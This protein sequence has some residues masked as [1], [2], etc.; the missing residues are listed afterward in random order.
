MEQI[1]IIIPFYN[2]KYVDQAIQSA[3]NQTYPDKEI[4]VVNDGSTKFLNKL[5]KFLDKIRYVEKDH[6][7]TA[8]ALNLG[9]QKARG[10]YITWLS[11]DDV[12]KREKLASQVKFMKE[13]EAAIS[14]SPY[15]RIDH[16]N[17]LV[18]GN[19]E[20]QYYYDTPMEF[21]RHLKRNCFINGSTIMIKK[22]LF[23]KIGL[24]DEKLVYAQDYDFWLRAAKHYKVHY[25]P[26]P[27]VYYRIHDDMGSIQHRASLL[28]EYIQVKRIHRN[29]VLSKMSGLK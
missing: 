19:I 28:K 25:H 5:N 10:D 1:S 3:L 22:E 27:N 13:K 14:Y 26:E 18:N 24:F 23:A 15:F 16:T 9:I 21:F 6:G 29:V 7:G 20:G 17:K 4:I 11:S 2:C 8:S 12:Y